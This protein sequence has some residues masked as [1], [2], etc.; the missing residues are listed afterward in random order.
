MTKDSNH[1][2]K[3]IACSPDGYQGQLYLEIN[4]LESIIEA[5]SFKA[6]GVKMK[7]EHRIVK[8]WPMRLAKRPTKREFEML[9]W[10]GNEG[11]ERYIEWHKTR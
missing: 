11:S 5:S 9:Y 6:S 2:V 8:K 10:S 7:P 1:L 4:A 3:T